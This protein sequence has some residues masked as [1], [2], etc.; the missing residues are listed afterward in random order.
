MRALK[1]L[2]YVI[3]LVG[4]SLLF[5]GIYNVFEKKRFLDE[6][7]SAEGSVISV[8][9]Y[10][11]RGT[12]TKSSLKYRPVIRFTAK[13]GRSTEFAG[14]STGDS[15]VYRTGDTVRV[16]YNPADPRDAKI[17]GWDALWSGP[18]TAIVIGGL[19]LLA[20]AVLY[21]FKE[22]EAGVGVYLR[23]F[24]VPVRT[25]FV[26]AK[27]NPL[28]YINDVH[29]FNI[30]SQWRNPRT[31]KMHEFTSPDVWSDLSQYVPDGEI[32]VYIKPDEPDTYR[33]DTSFLSAK[34][35][36]ALKDPF[37]TGSDANGADGW[38]TPLRTAVRGNWVYLMGAPLFGP[39]VFLLKPMYR[40]PIALDAVLF[41][42]TLGLAILPVIRRKAPPMFWF[43]AVG[44]WTAGIVVGAALTL[45]VGQQ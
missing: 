11:L 39:Y 21:A 24:G 32:T 27:P 9:S 4:L 3:M 30:V 34:A 35:P 45:F 13:D 8:E 18:A 6:A 28:T 38:E 1:Q 2:K 17:G 33:M 42:A 37:A 7:D 26:A 16:W 31:G 23:F 14:T 36:P 25:T 40:F 5:G 19:I 41:F 20:F 15:S 29:P 12:G 43:L 22:Y 44:I 10:F